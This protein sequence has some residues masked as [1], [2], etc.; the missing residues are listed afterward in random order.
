M[1]TTSELPKGRHHIQNIAL[2][3]AS[4]FIGLYYAVLL[5]GKLL[6]LGLAERKRTNELNQVSK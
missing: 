1:T 4:P 3:L 2:F 6:K 5:P